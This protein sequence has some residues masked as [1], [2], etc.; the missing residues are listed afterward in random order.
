MQVFT[1]KSKNGFKRKGMGGIG[2]ESLEAG[3]VRPEL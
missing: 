1:L 2:G 3:G